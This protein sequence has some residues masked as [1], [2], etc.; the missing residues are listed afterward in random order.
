MFVLYIVFSLQ[1]KEVC[2]GFS[3]LKEKHIPELPLSYYFPG[4]KMVV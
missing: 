4:V 1:V 2:C 3:V